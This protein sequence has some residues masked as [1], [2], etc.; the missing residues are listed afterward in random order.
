M[1][2]LAKEDLRWFTETDVS[3]AEDE[4]LL[5]MMRDAGCQQVLIGFESPRFESINGVEK[6]SNWK[7]RRT[8]FDINFR[9]TGMSVDDLRNGIRNLAQRLY[10]PDFVARRDRAFRAHLRNAVR[11]RRNPPSA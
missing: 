11:T 1:K 9:P 7:A 5:R 8:L 2:A 10:A 4:D 6:K 3:V